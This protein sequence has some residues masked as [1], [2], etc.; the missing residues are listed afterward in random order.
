MALDQAWGGLWIWCLVQLEAYTWML[1][2]TSYAYINFSPAGTTKETRILISIAHCASCEV[3]NQERKSEVDCL[4]LCHM[5]SR[6]F[7]RG[8]GAT[9][10]FY[11]VYLTV[12]RCSGFR[13]LHR[14]HIQTRRLN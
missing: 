11:G 9:N 5:P 13:L 6:D 4:M 12:D 1:D 3:C 8:L 14:M 10:H 2:D 7:R